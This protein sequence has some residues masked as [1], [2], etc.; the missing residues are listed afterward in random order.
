ML[1]CEILV[2][3]NCFN[4]LLGEHNCLSPYN[5]TVAGLC[6]LC[7]GNAVTVLSRH[8]DAAITAAG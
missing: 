2:E 5:T 4:A 6:N 8:Q 1:I 3:F 7:R